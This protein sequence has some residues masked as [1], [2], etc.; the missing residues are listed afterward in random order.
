MTHIEF[1]TTGQTALQPGATRP[2]VF[3]ELREE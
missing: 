3:C 2:T 1:S